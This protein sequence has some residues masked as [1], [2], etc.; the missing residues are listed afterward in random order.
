MDL[1]M[2]IEPFAVIVNG[3][4]SLKAATDVRIDI[5]SFQLKCGR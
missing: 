2:R 4:E 5:R 3:R 1:R